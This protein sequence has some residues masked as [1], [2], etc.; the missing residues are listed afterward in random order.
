[1]P[2]SSHSHHSEKGCKMFN[3]IDLLIQP[4]DFEEGFRT[5]NKTLETIGNIG[6]WEIWWIW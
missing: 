2:N 6:F 5:E 1:M 3:L 4:M